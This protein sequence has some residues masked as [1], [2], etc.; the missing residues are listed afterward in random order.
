M[1]ASSAHTRVPRWRFVILP[2]AVVGLAGCGPSPDLDQELATVHSWTATAS[3][4]SGHERSGAI[5]HR[6]A[7]QVHD[8]AAEARRQEAI[9]L[10]DLARS[11]SERRRAGAA[12]DSLDAALQGLGATPVAR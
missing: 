10:A 4:A 6:L 9:T 12:L 1:T 3:L 5:S 7:S 2:A 8:R 11:T